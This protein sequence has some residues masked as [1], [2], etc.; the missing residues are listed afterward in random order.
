MTRSAH[1]LCAMILSAACFAC[2]PPPSP[3]PGA[4]SP[5][6]I[7]SAPCSSGSPNFLDH[8]KFVQNGY[9]PIT[10]PSTPPAAPPSNIG[11]KIGSPYA[12]V[13]QNAFLL[14]PKP[15]QDRLCG[16]TGVYVNGPV[17]CSNLANCI[18]QG[19]GFRVW[20][21]FAPNETYIAIP[22]GLWSLPP[23]TSG[24]PPPQSY[25]YHCFETDLLKTLLGW[26]N[27]LP[28]QYSSANAE[29][30][31]FDMTIL[32]A[33]A[34]EVG[35]VQWYQTMTPNLPGNSIFGYN[36]NGFLCTDSPGPRSFF[37]YSWASAITTPPPWRP[38][39][40]RDV[41][42]NQPAG[43]LHLLPPQITDIDGDIEQ[44]IKQKTHTF[45]DNTTDLL[46]QLYQ[47]AQP[48]TS[49]FATASAD[50]DFV[51]TYKFYILTHANTIS[52]SEGPLTSLPIVLNGR[53]HDIPHDYLANP[54]K[55]PLLVAKVNC[56][57]PV[58]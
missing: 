45:L 39:S 49:F 4:P 38:F 13:L 14:A 16:L 46:G 40:T 10:D 51:E 17:T 1:L 9:T 33:L 28:P 11:A 30:D 34:H 29:A 37:S 5:V 47:R 35:H 24:S 53:D 18:D 22:A 48:W 7:A 2:A 54:S 6:S 52:Q 3:P 25:V 26:P 41:R 43:D 50:E 58:I 27:S 19:W 42:R 31:N 21:L 36:P 55:K 8:V 57:A 56:I 23:C 12:Q 20:H 44:Y 15:F 32:A